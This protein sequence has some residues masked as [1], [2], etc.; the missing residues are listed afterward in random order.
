MCTY[1]GPF[2]NPAG[3]ACQWTLEWMIPRKQSE[4]RWGTLGAAWD[5]TLGGG[6]SDVWSEGR[7][8]AG[9]ERACPLSPLDPLPSSARGGPFK[10]HDPRQKP[11]DG[12]WLLPPAI[13]QPRSIYLSPD[14]HTRF[15]GKHVRK[16]FYS[17]P[18]SFFLFASLPFTCRERA[19]VHTHSLFVTVLTG[20]PFLWIANS[21][22]PPPLQFLKYT[23]FHLFSV[24]FKNM[25][26]S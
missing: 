11:K 3:C 12:P 22:L 24:F 6:M 8:A 25:P 16:L 7:G 1:W 14:P 5:G 21:I 4:Q 15:W 19:P 10:V 2:F 17:V 20:F 13:W 18:S 23:R 9:S 26:S